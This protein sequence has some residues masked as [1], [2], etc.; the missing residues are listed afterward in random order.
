VGVESWDFF[1][2]PEMRLLEAVEQLQTDEVE[3]AGEAQEHEVRN[4][5]VNC[6][7][8][9]AEILIQLAGLSPEPRWSNLRTINTNDSDCRHW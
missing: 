1:P 9:A 7:C 2:W 6:S 3:V 4:M 8:E 5:V